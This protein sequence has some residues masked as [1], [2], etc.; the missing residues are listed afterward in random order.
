MPRKRQ[1]KRTYLKQQF[2]ARDLPEMIDINGEIVVG[3]FCFHCGNPLS[4][5]GPD[6]RCPNQHLHP[7]FPP[8]NLPYA[9]A[10]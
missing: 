3:P 5:H 4:L 6:S 10:S 8:P 2:A 1:R 9:N 7:L